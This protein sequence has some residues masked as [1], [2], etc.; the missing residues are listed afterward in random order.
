[1]TLVVGVAGSNDPL[2][3]SP[4]WPLDVH[5]HCYSELFTH[6]VE[7]YSQSTLREKDAEAVPWSLVA[8]R[9]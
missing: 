1:M 3:F 7:R 2:N 4:L 6:R 8:V 9:V 5:I